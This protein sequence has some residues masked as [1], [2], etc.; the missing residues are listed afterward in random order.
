MSQ[1]NSECVL[2]VPC[3]LPLKFDQN[4][5]SNSRDIPYIE[6]VLRLG[7]GFDNMSLNLVKSH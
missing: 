2:F 3:N 1:L 4:G 5:V 6:F 7:L